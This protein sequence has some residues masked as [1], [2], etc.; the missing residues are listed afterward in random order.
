MGR[1]RIGRLLGTAALVL[2]LGSTTAC[3]DDDEPTEASGSPSVT[4][5]SPTETSPPTTS[6][7]ESSS[8]TEATGTTMSPSATGTPSSSSAAPTEDPVDL[9]QPPATYADAEAHIEAAGVDGST[10]SAERFSTPGDVVYC[11]L[12]SPYNEPA[13]E[14]RV[15]AVKAPDVC[16]RAASDRVGRVVLT[17][18]GAEPECNTDTIR[19]PGA[20]VVRPL[21][22]VTSGSIECA[23]ES[24]GVTCVDTAAGTGFFITQGDYAIF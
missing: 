8:P 23:V 14:L 10:N 9:T 16:G 13:C 24:I 15:G 17:P 20:K 1:M 22:V 4:E 7:A 21:G 12:V 6:G 2:A 18:R 11:V 5:S 3:G 19:E